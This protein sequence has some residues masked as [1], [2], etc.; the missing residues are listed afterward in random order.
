[1]NEVK[2]LDFGLA[3]LTG[4]TVLTRTG[5]T[6]GT[7]AYMSPEQARGEA[8]DQRTDIW[9]LGV[10]LDE[11]LTGRKPFES[12]FE[13]ALVYEILNVDPKPVRSLRPEVPEAVEQT[14]LKALAKEPDNRYQIAEDL[15]ADLKAARTPELTG[16]TIAASEAL[17][18][19]NRRNRVRLLITAGALLLGLAGL[20]LVAIPLM[21]DQA[22]A[23]NPKSVAFISFENNTGDA[24]LGY[25]RGVLPDVLGS[26]LEDSKYL[27]LV[28]SDRLRE[29]MKQ[30]GKDSVEFI[31][32][33]TGLQLCHKA[34]IEVMGIGRFTKSGPLYLAELELIEVNTGERLGKV[35]KARGRGDESF[36]EAKGIVEDL[37]QQVPQGLGVSLLR[38][39]GS[40][41][42]I[43]E[44]S[45]TS[46]EAQRYYQRGRQEF[47]RY[48]SKDAQH[49]FEL[50]V[51]E[52]STF[53]I[54]WY[55]LGWTCVT[56]G[57]QRGREFAWGQALKHAS[58]ATEREQFMIA[59]VDSSLRVSLLASKGRAEMA[60][61]DRS[62]L[63]AR[64]E[65]FPFDARFLMEYAAD[66]R[67]TANEAVSIPMFEKVLELDPTMLDAYNEL[68][69]GYTFIGPPEKGMEWLERYAELQ[70]GDPNPFHSMAE[71]L[72]IQR[73]FGEAITKCER[74]LEAKPDFY[75]APQTLARLCFMKEDYDG[76]LAWIDR[77]RLIA[78]SPYLQA[79]FLWWRAWYLVWAGR[80]REAEAALDEC[81]RISIEVNDQDLRGRVSWLRGWCACEAGQWMKSRRNIL[82]Y[83]SR[84]H[85][86]WEYHFYLG[87]LALQ[88][89]KMDSL[90]GRI[91]DMNDSLLVFVSRD[92]PKPGE[93][94]C[95]SRLNALTNARHVAGGHPEEVR[96]TWTL[97]STW[98]MHNP[99]SFTTASWPLYS[100]WAAST[101]SLVWIPIP[102][103]ILPRAYL[104]R[105][106]VDSAIAAY[107]VALKKP[108]H[109]LGPIIPRYYYRV[110]RLY[111]QKGMKEKAI[112][113][114]TQ[115]L[116]V[117]GKADPVYKEPADARKRLARLKSTI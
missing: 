99:D 80:L 93:K 103:D 70:P 77:G 45:S 78:P 44:V 5:S 104:A 57:D 73:K 111:E 72:L 61:D 112:E 31:D 107:E 82:D 10:V 85:S 58:R 12:E 13:Q 53:A 19:K 83:T 86:R 63:K 106:L 7:A 81:N 65:I 66:I 20:F 102:F 28:S 74:A 90:D 68:G 64:C 3:K 39:Q 54:A 1:H 33:Q 14:I 67:S 24:S 15:L 108:P 26:S 89:K 29:L 41:K 47:D 49:Y 6:L 11:M 91:R 2:I 51:K 30:I 92:D 48:N 60:K 21:Q 25:L 56:M 37:A 69:Y 75:M 50:S 79:D 40:V 23:S 109:L 87:L 88:E 96:L 22:L 71:C 98:F 27:R 101:S 9:S 115:F 110:A 4:Q 55:W 17:A 8:L 42:A 105:G 95:R 16:V 35:L 32:K 84:R 76:A 38:S 59:G 116:K 62:F 36:L 94:W 52:D 43:A 34:R 114:Y 18:R 97:K 117:W 100:G 46:M 113:N